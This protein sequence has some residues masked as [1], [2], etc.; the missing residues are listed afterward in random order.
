MWLLNDG[1]LNALLGYFIEFLSK[2]TEIFILISTGYEY[3]FLFINFSVKTVER[4]NKVWL[5]NYELLKALL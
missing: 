2:R 1:M 5:L 3:L 4:K